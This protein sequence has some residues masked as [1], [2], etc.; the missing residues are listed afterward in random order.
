MDNKIQCK[1]CGNFFCT[2]N[3]TASKVYC[4]YCYIQWV[5][6]SR[7]NTKTIPL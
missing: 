7:D 5:V 2:S 4:G 3:N 6:H 1:S